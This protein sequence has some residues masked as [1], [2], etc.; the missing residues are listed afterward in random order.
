MYESRQ[1][2]NTFSFSLIYIQDSYFRG[3]SSQPYISAET[4]RLKI[5][6]NWKGKLCLRY[7][8][9][10]P[11]NTKVWSER[12]KTYLMAFVQRTCPHSVSTPKFYL[13]IHRF[14]L[15][16]S[17]VLVFWV[18]NKS[19]GNY[20]RYLFQ[21]TEIVFI[22]HNFSSLRSDYAGISRYVKRMWKT[23]IY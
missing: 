22:I 6:R 9:N 12:K 4:K 23:K 7:F 18:F 8:K 13:K 21:I 19:K 5:F 16:S 15:I 11:S 14:V 1:Y 20:L 10:F 2:D 3:F 17:L